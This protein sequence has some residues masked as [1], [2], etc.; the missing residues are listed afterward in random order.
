MATK[1]TSKTSGKTAAGKAITA[2]KPAASKSKV[3]PKKKEPET[4]AAPRPHAAAPPKP[5]AKAPPSVPTAPP[6]A[7]T[8]RRNVASV[9]LIDKKPTQKKAADGEIKKK[10]AVLPP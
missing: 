9:S 7:P 6:P 3:V 8:P 4:K 2:S 5:A 1:T 10:T